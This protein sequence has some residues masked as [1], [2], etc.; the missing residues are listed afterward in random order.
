[1]AKYVDLIINGDPVRMDASIWALLE[2]YAAMK[3]VS[4]SKGLEDIIRSTINEHRK[5]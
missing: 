4:V 1:M 5:V 2:K 3:G